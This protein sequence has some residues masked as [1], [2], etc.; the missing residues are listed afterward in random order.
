MGEKL[1]FLAK[2]LGS[3]EKMFVLHSLMKQMCVLHSPIK[4]TVFSQ[5]YCVPLRKML[6][7]RKSVEFPHETLHSLAKVLRYPLKL[8]VLSQKCYVPP[9]NF[10]FSL[11]SIAFPHE[12]LRF[13]IKQM[14]FAFPHET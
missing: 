11:K 13:P 5:N 2:V 9:R 14:C 6:F 7:S 12:P 3:L 4:K 1:C 8:C 10:K